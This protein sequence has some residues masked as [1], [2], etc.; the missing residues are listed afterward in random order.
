MVGGAA[1][2]AG[3][4]TAVDPHLTIDVGG[5]AAT[6]L[7]GVSFSTLQ[8]AGRVVEHRDGAVRRADALFATPS[9][10]PCTTRF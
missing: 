4:T 7:G 9:A 3:S 8:A 2:D 6:Y 1:G 10:P 5:L